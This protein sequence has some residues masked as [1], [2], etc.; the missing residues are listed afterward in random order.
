MNFIT[1]LPA[2]KRAVAGLKKILSTK[3][4][5]VLR[6]GIGIGKT[7]MAGEI[8]KNYV[9]TL[10]VCEKPE[11]IKKKLYQVAGLRNFE[12]VHYKSFGDVTKTD[13]G[14][15]DFIVYDE[16]H[17]LK[18][19]SSS[20][21]KRMVMLR[22]GSRKYLFMSGTP[23]TTKELDSIYC[24]RKCGAFSNLSMD[25]LKLKYFNGSMERNP[26][27]G[28]NFVKAHSLSDEDGF[29]DE[30]DD[31]TIVLK[32]E[33]VGRNIPPVNIKVRVL[34][35][36]PR[37]FE[38]IT[39][40]TKARLETGLSKVDQAI[41]DIRKVWR[42][43]GVSTSLILCHFHD[44]AKQIGMQLGIKPALTK[45]QV[46]TDFDKVRKQGGHIVTTLGLTK[47]SLDLNECD[48]VFLIE[49]NYAKALDEQSID[50]C[51]RVGKTTTLNV[52]YYTFRGEHTFF[53]SIS[54]SYL[55]EDFSKTIK[56]KIYP[57]SLG[58]LAEC[59]GS[60]W[61]PDKRDI[62]EYIEAAAVIGEKKHLI[63]ERYL[64]HNR[65]VSKSAT[66]AVSF[67]VEFCRE[68]K[69]DTRQWGCETRGKFETDEFVLSG[70]I[71]FW[72]YRKEEDTLYIFDYKN[73]KTPVK[74]KD[75]WQ[76]KA[77][78][79]MMHD[80]L[81]T[82]P[83]KFVVGILQDCKAKSVEF[84]LKDISKI[85]REYKEITDK[86]KAAKDKP[87]DHLNKGKCSIFCKAADIHGRVNENI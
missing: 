76:L 9:R 62:P 13:I 74:A 41:V 49:S 83:K 54:R 81:G 26:H 80:I 32:K 10:F 43:E 72:A 85:K 45:K 78:A 50:R 34:D 64:S 28:K 17:N 42:S 1:L 22:G 23:E 38:K 16:C 70:K 75:N 14:S 39:E 58:I 60:Y 21:T 51:R 87:L 15:Y 69:K 57:S 33:D 19:Y 24:Y 73:G 18:N 27:T 37:D 53:K 63:L 68:L 61:L 6:G 20:Y 7:F 71:D 59:P 86:I 30:L 29:Y 77:Y 79:L 44:V 36:E 46:T 52:V 56:N 35:G 40:C 2:Q 11:D 47:S 84:T 55:L 48:W 12:V 66:P 65:P 31:Y 5:A 25:E 4:G 3:N 67:A 82:F 8:A